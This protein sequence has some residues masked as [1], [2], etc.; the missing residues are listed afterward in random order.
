MYQKGRV[1]PNSSSEVPTVQTVKQTLRLL[2]WGIMS[3]IG[4]S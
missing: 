1:R 3:Y 4:I 2:T